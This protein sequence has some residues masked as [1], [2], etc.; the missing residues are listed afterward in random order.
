MG[1]NTSN[2]LLRIAIVLPH[3]EIQKKYWDNP[4]IVF[5]DNDGWWIINEKNQRVFHEIGDINKT[6][7]N[8]FK[9]SVTKD[10]AN[11]RKW[12][13][14]ISRWNDDGDQF[15]LKLRNILHQ[16]FL[17]ACDLSTLNVKSAIFGTGISHHVYPF[18]CENACVTAN[19]EQIFLYCDGFASRLIPVIQTKSISDRRVLKLNISN[20][21]YSKSIHQM[22]DLKKID[23]R[24]VFNESDKW[25][26]SYCY[27]IIYLFFVTFLG[28]FVNRLRKIIMNKGKLFEPYYSYRLHTFYRQIKQQKKAIWFYK[29]NLCDVAKINDNAKLLIVAHYQPEATSFPEGGEFGNHLDIVLELRSKGYKQEIYYKEHPGSVQ[30]IGKGVGPTRVG[31]ARSENYYKQLLSLGC[32]FL[33]IDYYI[34]IKKS[35]FLPITIVGTIAI[36]RSLSGLSTIYVGEPWWKGLPGT[37]SIND[38]KSLVN[39]N[40]MLTDANSDNAEKSFN[41]FT[42]MLNNNTL[43]NTLG[44]GSGVILNDQNQIDNFESEYDKLISYLMKAT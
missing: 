14:V 38:I 36:E 21:N 22:L 7:N 27:S 12:G 26:E 40:L 16:S 37:I 6:K 18:I 1:I 39:I 4:K 41:F 3:K 9:Y 34:P 43:T 29:N 30:Y 8:N 19:I 33:P 42:E 5:L 11:I 35:N 25:Q 24:Q 23:K 31:M 28:Q 32:K 10:I 44:I 13:P 15:E 17:I 2:N 20:F